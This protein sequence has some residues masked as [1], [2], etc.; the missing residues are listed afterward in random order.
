[1]RTR[2]ETKERLTIRDCEPLKIKLLG[3]HRLR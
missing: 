2:V 3:K 1:M